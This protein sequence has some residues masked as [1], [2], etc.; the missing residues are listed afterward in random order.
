GPDMPISMR[1]DMAQHL[2]DSGV[3]EYTALT[4]TIEANLAAQSWQPKEEAA[5]QVACQWCDNGKTTDIGHG[6]WHCSVCGYTGGPESKEPPNLPGFKATNKKRKPR[7]A[8][9]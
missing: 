1:V 8:P 9:T 2:S 4:R 3:S 5:Y 7:K 6:L